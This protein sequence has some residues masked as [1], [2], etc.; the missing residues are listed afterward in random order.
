MVT[1]F[2]IM[3]INN[4]FLVV[5]MFVASKGYNFWY[6]IFFVTFYYFSVLI[7][8]NILVAYTIDMYASVERLDEER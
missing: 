3:V 1:L 7:A 8:L 5:D 6:R 2:T 4:W